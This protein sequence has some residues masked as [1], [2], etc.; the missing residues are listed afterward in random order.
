[1]SN[2]VRPEVIITCLKKRLSG[3]T[4]T[5]INLLPVQAKL[6]RLGAVGSGAIC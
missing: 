1:M 2:D 4:T 5:I 3:V 6:L